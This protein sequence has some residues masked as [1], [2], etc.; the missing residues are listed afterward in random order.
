MNRIIYF[1]ALISLS[2]SG[3]GQ[4][5]SVQI[6]GDVYIN[7]NIL[8]VTEAG[9]DLPSSL[10]AQSFVHVSLLYEDQ[11]N[12]NKNPNE[13][14]RV[15]IHKQDIQ[16][17]EDLHLETRRTGTG[18]KLDNAGSPNIQDGQNFQ[19]INNNPVYFFRGMGEIVQIP[20]AMKLNGF[21]LTMGSRDFET[22]LV[23][24]VYDEW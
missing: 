6:E 11:L 15:F 13:K 3:T 12:K 16:W 18:S 20:L 9:E 10:E 14:W 1:I 17:D 19:H 23:F 8:S 24:T 4:Q 22:A 7:N 2:F 5:L 21:S